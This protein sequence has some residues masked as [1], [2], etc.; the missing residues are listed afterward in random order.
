MIKYLLPS[1]LLQAPPESGEASTGQTGSYAT[2]IHTASAGAW[3][4]VRMA[5]W[6]SLPIGLLG[7]L[8]SLFVLQ[9]YNRVISRGGNA[10]LIAMVA[11]VLVFLGI[12]WWLRRKRAKALREAGAEIDYHVSQ[13]LL[14]SMLQ[15]P[16]LTLEQRPASQWLQLFRDV[17]AMR[18]SISGGLAGAFMDI[19]MVLLALI[20]IGIVAWPVLP[21][22]LVAMV[23]LGIL[24]WWWADE[25]RTGRVEE[26][27]QARALDRT[28]TEVCNARTTL[29][30]LGHDQAVRQTWQTSYDQW[31]TESFS[32]NGEL[33]NAREASTM[34]LSFFSIAVI[35]VGAI[36]INSQWMSIGS[37]MA[38]N[39]LASKALGP[40][41]QLA[42]NWRSLA[43]AHDATRRLQTVLQEPVEP[44]PQNLQL[45]RPQGRLRLEQVS[46]QYH[47][48]HTPLEQVS[49]EMGPGGLH[50]IV[51]RNGAGKSTLGKLLAG[52]YR[53]TEGHLFIDEYDLAQFSRVDIG[54]W[55][56][57]LSQ[58]V[59]WFSGPIIESLRM[60]N[61]SATDA[62]IVAACQ[63]SG[64]HSFISRL[65]QGY[66]T[67]LG[68][69]GAGL[70]AGELRKLALAQLFLRNPSVLILDEPSSDLDFESETALLQALLK[71]ASKHTVVVITHSVRVASVAQKIYHVCGDGQLEVGTPQQLLPKLFG[72]RP[73]QASEHTQTPASDTLQEEAA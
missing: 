5:A 24:A 33:E 20:V 44:A 25:V 12:E 45:P 13:A 32:K 53:P 1:S 26:I 56:G 6:L 39:L 66:Q 57:C 69:G 40:I 23:I 71:I 64:A 15:R 4:H 61:E 35:T 11:G 59:Y 68:E 48:G 52:L 51:G 46:F 50:A 42:G 34:L 31:L 2:A 7:L 49:L 16:L 29:K 30:V 60:V 54:Q 21:V 43:R 37:L 17:G 28:T 22:I 8:P 72:V 47:A 18:S 9:V 62:Q 38:V 65:P 14:A 27:A 58:Q 10:T 55:I 67:T 73:A 3:Q 70:S 63:L 19:P 41:A 36:A